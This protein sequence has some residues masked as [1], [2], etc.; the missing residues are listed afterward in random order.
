M[1]IRDRWSLLNFIL[2]DIFDSLAQFQGWFDFDHSN[3]DDAHRIIQQEAESQ[4]VA[5]LHSIM[6]PFMLRRQKKDVDLNIPKKKEIVVYC[7]S[8][9]KQ[10]QMYRN[11]LQ[12]RSIN[13]PESDDEEEDMGR[14][15]RSRGG[16]CY[17]ED[18][19][20]EAQWARAVENDEDVDELEEIK[21]ASKH[22]GG[23][24]KF[25][26]ADGI[27][28]V[29][30]KKEQKTSLNNLLMQL[31]KVCN[32]PYLFEEAD[33][34][35]TDEA[36][37]RDAGKMVVLDKLL[38]KL[39]DRGH[40]VLI[41]SQMTKM[42]SII[43]DYLIYRHV[44]Y[45]RI[46]GSTKLDERQEAMDNFNTKKAYNCFLLS[47]RAG[48]LGINL[49]SADTVIIFDSDWNPQA[50]L[51]AQ[52]RCHRIGQTKPV[53]VYRLCAAK[54]VEE[55]MLEKAANKRKL[56]HLIVSNGK[57]VEAG[58]TSKKEDI[59]ALTQQELLAMLEDNYSDETVSKETLTE[60]DIEALLD[61]TSLFRDKK[62]KNVT[63]VEGKFKVLSEDQD[64][65][66]F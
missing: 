17:D 20:T 24:K 34:G 54:S 46:D 9:E 42:L 48:G 64:A 16:V 12:Y 58:A 29:A 60:E 11:I 47:T 52:D 25:K 4:I 15:Q 44:Q 49:V 13:K 5:K 27:T 37:V 2:P 41:F 53:L 26:Q 57:F 43:E 18:S 62:G 40:K 30:K 66:M 33:P 39:F 21:M 65:P 56:E 55:Q 36:I 45:C 50:D 14:G 8:S 38:T 31:R 59:Q 6:K 22:G 23:K 3:V 35:E 61:R 32:H 51:Q 1:C 7:S 10:I 28:T 63:E 19:M